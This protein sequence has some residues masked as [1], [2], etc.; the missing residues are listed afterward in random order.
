MTRL[1]VGV[2]EN[3]IFNSV[4]W[5]LGSN[6]TVIKVTNESCE[7]LGCNEGGA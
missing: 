7:P 1:E 6:T 3:I 5:P 2:E 4:A